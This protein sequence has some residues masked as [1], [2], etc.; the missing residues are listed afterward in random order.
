MPEIYPLS[1]GMRAVHY[2]VPGS[3][4]VHCAL[5]IK[6]GARDE[7]AGKTGLAH[8]IEHTFFKG[9]K[10]RSSKQVLS[11]LEENGGEL[12][13]Y[14]TKEE[15]CIHA[16]VM[17]SELDKAADIISDI[18]INATFPAEELEKEKQVIIDEIH[19]YEDTPYEQIYDDF[20]Q[21]LFHKHP[22]GNPILGAEKEINRFQ[23]QD[24]IRF[25]SS[26]YSAKNIIWIVAGDVSRDDVMRTASFFL[27]S[28]AKGRLQ[29][30]APAGKSGLRHEILK[31]V[32]QFH[33]IMGRKAHSFENKDRYAM[34]LLNNVLGGPA[35]NSILNMN[36][37]EKYGYTYVIESG[38]HAF[39]DTGIFHI[40]F[41]TDQRYFQKTRDLVYKELQKLRNQ[42]LS[43]RKLKKYREQLCGQLI[44]A[45]E[46]RL[47]VMLGM[48]RSALLTGKIPSL[49]ELLDSIRSVNTSQFKKVA[50]SM[51]NPEEMTELVYKPAEE[52]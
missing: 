49:D 17:R 41:A 39:S 51:L 18:F 26:R 46:N 52:T 29:R 6:C 35:M 40:Y 19:A 34:M 36:I 44:M 47:N 28:K 8:F 43:E 24:I 20:E 23:R 9:T 15:T 48:G 32:S 30:K 50:G 25:M 5:M 33:F 10:K 14:T 42:P 27:K 38:Y 2:A 1:N 21:L 31:P 11:F 45:Q 13:A 37:R 7:P 3:H 12:N 4:V 22:M 16:S